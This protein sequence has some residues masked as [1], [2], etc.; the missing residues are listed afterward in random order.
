MQEAK[1]PSAV[2]SDPRCLP[3]LAMLEPHKT[4]VTDIR[5]VIDEC[6]SEIQAASED[7]N[8]EEGDA[9]GAFEEDCRLRYPKAPE[10]KPEANPTNRG[11]QGEPSLSRSLKGVCR[12]QYSK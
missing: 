5:K 12:H 11:P 10:A 7:G 1:Q 4:K 3:S 2:T 9:L 6:K 8:E